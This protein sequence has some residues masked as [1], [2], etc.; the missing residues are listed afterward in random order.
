MDTDES[1][2]H[3]PLRR[4]EPSPEM[5]EA[6]AKMRAKRDALLRDRPAVRARGLDALGRLLSIAQGD[7]GQ[8]RVVAGFL[9]GC[10]NGTRFP[11]DLTDFRRLDHEIFCDCLAVLELDFQPEREVHTYFENGSAIWERL[12]THWHIPDTSASKDPR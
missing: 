8:C 3:T 5:I 7:S 11:F 10:Y 12:A 4:T 2:R 1:N 6:M 9:L